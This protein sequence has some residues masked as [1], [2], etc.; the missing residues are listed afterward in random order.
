MQLAQENSLA[1][2][3]PLIAFLR[4]RGQEVYWEVK[5]TMSTS[6]RVLKTSLSSYL[7]S[8]K[9]V[10]KRLPSSPSAAKTAKAAPAS[11]QATPA[12]GGA[13]GHV[14]VFDV[15]TPASSED[16]TRRDGLP[17]LGDRARA[18]AAET[19]TDVVHRQSG[20][21]TGCSIT[22]SSEADRV[23]IDTATF[24]YAFGEVF[25]RGERDV[26][27]S[28]AARRAYNTFVAQ[29]VLQVAHD[30]VV[31]PSPCVNNAHRR[32]MSRRCVPALDAYIDNV[33][34]TLWPNFKSAC[35]LHIKSL[36]DMQQLFN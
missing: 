29:G 28:L 13:C 24:E 21:E 15:S 35:D 32:V 25:W 34:M 23:L 8:L 6:G 11:A 7:E 4:E 26:F 19:T 14:R 9:I 16:G 36:D 20:G 27:E 22:S 12:P 2:Y 17:V 31:Y 30:A 5:S 3:A 1:K 18:R 10:S 33:N